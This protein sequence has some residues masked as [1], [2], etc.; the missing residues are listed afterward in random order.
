[1]VEFEGCCL[2]TTEEQKARLNA[3]H[4]RPGIGIAHTSGPFDLTQKFHLITFQHLGVGG[5]T[6]CILPPLKDFE[7][8]KMGVLSK[9]S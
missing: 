7:L 3:G 8:M 4:V 5:N 1:M 6:G 2:T 9:G